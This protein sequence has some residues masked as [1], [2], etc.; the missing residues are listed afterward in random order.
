MSN[1]ALFDKPSKDKVEMNE[2]EMKNLKKISMSRGL[3]LKKRGEE[4]GKLVWEKFDMN[5]GRTKSARLHRNGHN[6]L[7][8]R[9]FNARFAALES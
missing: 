2:R 3:E 8:R 1:V 6:S 5:P 7:H 9:N 4:K